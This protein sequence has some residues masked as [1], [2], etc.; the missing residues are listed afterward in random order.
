MEIILEIIKIG[1]PS[2]IVFLT[3]YY[4]LKA[5]LDKQNQLQLLEIQKKQKETTIPMR[6]QAYERLS[7]FCERISI[8]NLVL[9]LKTKDANSASLRV[10]LLLAV[11][12]EFEHNISQ[13]IY[14]S[15]KLWQII[16]FAKDDT[17]NTINTIAQNIDPKSNSDLLANALM[18]Y[19]E[20][21]GSKALDTALLAIRKETA[22]LL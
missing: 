7:L 11:Q 19:V 13:Q 21:N 10:S 22:I 5:F 17:V 1:L 4:V 9:R 2:L 15:D 20:Q 6:F 16:K 14:V 8:P 12:Q 18:L 3:V